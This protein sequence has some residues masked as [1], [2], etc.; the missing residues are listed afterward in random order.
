MRPVRFLLLASFAAA[1]FVPGCACPS[2]EIRTRPK[3][4]A[5]SPVVEAPAGGRF[6]SAFVEASWGERSVPRSGR[7]GI[8]NATFWDVRRVLVLA[9][10][11]G[12]SRV[13]MPGASG[14]HSDAKDALAALDEN[15]E[16]KF[17]PDGRGLAWARAG[18]AEWGWVALDVP[19]PFASSRVKLK[20]G[21][22]GPPGRGLVVEAMA[23]AEKAGLF[24]QP[25]LP[26]LGRAVEIALATGE[27]EMNR[28]AARAVAAGGCSFRVENM[29]KD[30]R[31]KLANAAAADAETR[32]AYLAFLRR[33]E[34]AWSY[35]AS[36][37]LHLLEASPASE[38]L[39]VRI[40]ALEALAKTPRCPGWG[41]G[42]YDRH[43]IGGLVREAER[44]GRLP[45]GSEEAMVRG[46]KD[47]EYRGGRLLLLHALAR[48]GSPKA[49][50]AIEELAAGAEGDL[51]P[52][53]AT[54]AGLEQDILGKGLEQ[55]YR[56]EAFAKVALAGTEK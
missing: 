32:G 46:L 8:G 39:P 23:E 55:K 45:E 43:L 10:A 30:L 20:A 13:P 5:A 35:G 22:W 14:E 25:G 2:A 11:P 12:E 34:A 29:P 27:P 40:A 51:P 33:P 36:N 19:L 1:A 26:D 4:R 37:A 42:S 24:E 52:W 9:A 56:V 17:A 15:F 16:L 48:L 21:E 53:P 47:L 41:D 44:G 28:R 31:E 7:G 3:T 50:T 18:A 38:V 54:V 6:K 49:R